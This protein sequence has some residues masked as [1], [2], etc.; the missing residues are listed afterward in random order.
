MTR[1]R[2]N[3]RRMSATDI[4]RWPPEAADGDVQERPP[5]KKIHATI[6]YTDDCKVLETFLRGGGQ[7]GS[8]VDFELDDIAVLISRGLQ[9][10]DTL[11]GLADG[12]ARDTR[13]RPQ[14]KIGI[15]LDKLCEMEN[16]LQASA[17]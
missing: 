13:N 1:T 7:V 17:K 11:R 12:V 8:D 3:N 14:S 6:G 4:V 5:G 16:V 9:R 10:G 2:M 15:I